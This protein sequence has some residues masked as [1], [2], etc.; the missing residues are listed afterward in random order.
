MRAILFLAAALALGG[1]A[2]RRPAAAGP[3]PGAAA[4][5]TEDAAGLQRALARAITDRAGWDTLDL[6]VECRTDGALTA[7]RVFGNGIGIWNDERQFRLDL[8]Q[9]GSLLRALQSAGFPGMEDTYG[10]APRPARPP[11]GAMVTIAIC[12]IELSLGGY[13]K[14][15]VQLVR[16]EQSPAL[17]ALADDLLRICQAPAR[18]GLTAASLRD[19]LEKVSRGE[20]A[21]ETLRIVAH[22]KPERKDDPPGFLLRVA[23]NRATTR[24]YEP[25][26]GY[27][28]PVVLQMHA[29]ELRALARELAARD[30]ATW[31]SNL[32]A[33]DYTDLSIRVLN[34][35]K[36]IQARR[37]AGLAPSAHG[38]QQEAFEEVFQ[39]LQGLHRKAL[40]QGHPVA[41]RLS[42]CGA[43]P[44]LRS[45]T[46]QPR[47]P[48]G[49]RLVWVI[50]PR[51]ARAVVYR[52]L[53]D[54]REL[55]PEDALDGEDVLPG[56]RCTLGEIL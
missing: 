30:P 47:R 16:G 38:R 15:A 37:F 36:A 14:R 26:R 9:I 50:D 55:G 53:S 3:A 52:S 25:A 45:A 40:E 42:R 34:H 32:Y 20:L 1:C 41:E 39:M 43:L 19:G 2:T 33:V 13:D 8:D 10:G 17:K 29:P 11:G 51:K 49:V 7:A 28:D 22:R 6:L 23:R 27:R 4:S 46:M 35:E 21:P 54:V 48:W 24:A 44:E 56:F 12:R 31:P 5:A 18:L